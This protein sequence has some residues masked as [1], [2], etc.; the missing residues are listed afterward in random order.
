M[1]LNAVASLGASLLLM[2]GL[3][4]SVPATL[5]AK[6]SEGKVAAGR[7]ERSRSSSGKTS[8]QSSTVT[9]VVA[10]GDNLGK[11]AKMHGVR[12][13]DIVRWN[14]LSSPDRISI[15]QKLSIRTSAQSGASGQQK[16]SSAAGQDIKVVYVVRKGDTL[17]GIAKQNGVQIAQL[18]R[19]NRALRDNPDRLR[20]GQQITLWVKAPEVQTTSRGSAANGTLVNAVQLPEGKGYRRRGTSRQWG[21]NLLVNHIMDVMARYHAKYPKGPD[22]VVGDLSFKNGGKMPPHVSHQSGRDVDISF[23]NKSGKQQSNFERMTEKNFDA[24][25]NWY[26]IKAF[27]DTGDVEYIFVDYE[28]Q[29]LM[30]DYARKKGVSES[31]LDKVLQYPNGKKSYKAIVRHARGHADHMHV[32]VVCPKGDK[33]CR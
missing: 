31:Y 24:E 7:G 23:V 1:R 33:Q 30:Y 22:F 27:V 18:Q 12:V 14:R 15:G 17:S 19:W 20:V 16:S 28:L 29:R 5:S 3:L 10:K 13:E 11:I 26:V 6:P 21:T 2:V 8:S 4:L 25:K 32:R 9:Y